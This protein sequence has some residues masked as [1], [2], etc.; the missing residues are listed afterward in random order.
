MSKGIVTMDATNAKHAHTMH[1]GN[2]TSYQD[3]YYKSVE[4]CICEIVNSAASLATQKH[5]NLVF[6]VTCGGAQSK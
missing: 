1:T 5:D 3:L 6:R 2:I 4:D